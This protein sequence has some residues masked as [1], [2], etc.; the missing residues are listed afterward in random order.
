MGDRLCTSSQ[1]RRIEPGPVFGISRAAPGRSWIRARR[2][3]LASWVDLAFGDGVDGG[4]C[5]RHVLGE[6]VTASGE[7]LGDSGVVHR[8]DVERFGDL[9]GRVVDRTPFV[10]SRR[11]RVVIAGLEGEQVRTFGGDDLASGRPLLV[12]ATVRA[13]EPCLQSRRLPRPVPRPRV[14]HQ[15]RRRRTLHPGLGPPP[16]CHLPMGQR[17]EAPRRALRLRRRQLARQ[18]LGRTPLPP[19][20][21]H[22]QEPPPRRTHPG[23][24]L[25]PHHPALPARPRAL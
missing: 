9:G 16:H 6:L 24:Q 14:A 17:Q 20:A 3:A 4:E 15:P 11:R 2:E 7:L 19:T 13:G 23:P 21:R 25:G 12:T 1:S 10:A 5:R 22:R 8:G 18:H